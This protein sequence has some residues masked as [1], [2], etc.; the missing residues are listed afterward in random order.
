MENPS[1]LRS[2][3]RSGILVRALVIMLAAGIVNAPAIF[4]TPLSVLKGW[5]AETVAGAATMMGTF[6]VVGHFFGGMLL[7]KI[8]AKNTVTIGG[9]AILLAFVGTALVPASAPV[10]LY[11]TYGAFFGIGVGFSYTPATYTA[12]GWFPDRRGLVSGACMACNG[13]SASFL[14]PIGAKLI[15]VVGVQ[16]AMIIIGIIL[17]GDAQMVF[18]HLRQLR[19]RIEGLHLPHTPSVGPWVT[20]SIGGV[21]V[22][23]KSGDDYRTYLNIA[24]TMLYDAKRF[25]RNQ[26]VW[27]GDAMKQLREK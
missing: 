16:T 18:D 5:E 24:D 15:N 1:P 19:K 2:V 17:G 6:T 22:T 13:G 4:V 10:L 8:G 7:S 21:T 23:P 25:G 27:C 14:A 12:L 11:V 9:L 20:V 26:V 3:D